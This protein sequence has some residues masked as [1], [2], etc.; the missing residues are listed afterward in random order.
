L[1]IDID[2]LEKR[3]LDLPGRLLGYGGRPWTKVLGLRTDGYLRIGPDG[4]RAKAERLLSEQGMSKGDMAKIWLVTMPSFLGFEGIN[5]L[6]V[7]YIYSEKREL[8]CVILEVHNT[9]GEK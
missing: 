1:G 9:F 6:S 4:M 2:A 7:W 3:E 5:P 8:T